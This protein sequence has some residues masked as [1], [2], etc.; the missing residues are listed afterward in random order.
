MGAHH[1]KADHQR[2]QPGAECRH[3]QRPPQAD[4]GIGRRQERQRVAGQAEI[5]GVA[6]RDQAAHPLQQV[7]AHGEDRQDH[8]LR[9][10]LQVEV[11]A[12]GGHQ[13]KRGE[14]DH[15]QRQQHLHAARQFFELGF[16]RTHCLNRPSGL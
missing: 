7:Q 10:H 9:E 5:G 11:G 3:R 13:R 12:V 8:H 14:R 6:E 4:G 2:R 1:K 16:G 15:T